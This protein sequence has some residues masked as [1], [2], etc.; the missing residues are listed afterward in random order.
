MEF[1]CAHWSVFE[2]AL[3]MAHIHYLHDGSFG[4]QANPV[5]HDMVVGGRGGSPLLGGL[6]DTSG[7]GVGPQ[8]GSFVGFF[9]AC[10]MDGCSPT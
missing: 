8:H 3:D 7:L 4:D 1:D 6:R 10:G 9:V 2:N 5:I